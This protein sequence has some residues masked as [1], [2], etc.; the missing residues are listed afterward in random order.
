MPTLIV[1]LILATKI[2][3]YRTYFIIKLKINVLPVHNFIVCQLLVRL[4]ERA[5]FVMLFCVLNLMGLY[6]KGL[7]KG[8]TFFP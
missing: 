5:R 1:C 8:E 2:C 7:K 3:E 4:H 6:L